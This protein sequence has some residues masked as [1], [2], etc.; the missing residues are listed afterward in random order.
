[1]G[2][3]GSKST[4]TDPTQKAGAAVSAAKT[5]ELSSS[6]PKGSVP[7]ASNPV[8]IE[9]AARNPNIPPPIKPP[10]EAAPPVAAPAAVP[11]PV[12][13]PAAVAPS[14][15]VASPQVKPMDS[16]MQVAPIHNSNSGPSLPKADEPPKVIKEFVPK[17]VNPHEFY[18]K[19]KKGKNIS[20]DSYVSTYKCIQKS[21]KKKRTVKIIRKEKIAHQPEEDNFF[22]REVSVLGQLDHPNIVRMF[23]VFQ[24]KKYYYIVSEHCKGKQIFERLSR[25]DNFSEKDV[26]RVMLQLFQAL[27]YCHGK[28]IVHRDITADSV[29]FVDK[30]SDFEIKVAD[31][32]STG[33]V[34]EERELV[35]DQQSLTFT[36]PEVFA[37]SFTTKCDIWSAGILLYLMLSGKKPFKPESKDEACEF[38]KNAELTFAKPSKIWEQVSDEAK[39]LIGK[40][41]DKN[42]R[43]RIAA[44]AALN[45]PWIQK[46]QGDAAPDAEALGKTS[47]R[48]SQFN[49][50]CKLKSA[51]NSFIASQLMS[52]NDIKALK[53]SFRAIDKNGDGK[54]SREELYDCYCQTMDDNSAMTE[55]EN[56][57][58]MVD[59]DGSGY[60]DY[61]EFITATVAAKKEMSKSQLK[62]AFATFDQ[63]GSGKISGDELK[64]AL[65]ELVNE[66]EWQGILQRVDSDSD[67]EIDL[68]EFKTFLLSLN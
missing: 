47:H 60:V 1:M 7:V 50:S 13:Q 39:D 67:G 19:Y 53:D 16:P 26:A 31:F 52:H 10:M 11:P 35:E 40:L 65:G 24:D 46:Y 5:G 38:L 43:N 30:G 37:G 6:Q 22:N 66:G 51:V 57:M 48:L 23:E 28:K 41:L 33:L 27:N 14:L 62:K 4:Q 9:A 3:G 32:G 2:C 34:D 63:D 55:V 64:A 29:L 56:M 36:A 44:D 54:L 49:S 18:D 12:E 45:H 17:N 59:T 68:K 20:E 8:P 21:T 58:K 42:P 25:K 61:T 15:A